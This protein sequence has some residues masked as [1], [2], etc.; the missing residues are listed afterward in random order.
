VGERVC[1]YAFDVGGL[2]VDEGVMDDDEKR[3][4]ISSMILTFAG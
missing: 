4:T 3:E 2:G 1:R